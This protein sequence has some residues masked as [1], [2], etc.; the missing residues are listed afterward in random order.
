MVDEGID[1]D[2]VLENSKK[3]LSS[4]QNRTGLKAST[5]PEQVEMVLK[6]NPARFVTLPIPKLEE[7]MAILS[8]YAIYIQTEYNMALTKETSAKDAYQMDL[9]R[10][11][12]Q[13]EFP[14]SISTKKERDNLILTSNERVEKLHKIT[15]LRSRAVM[16]LE[17]QADRLE[18]LV[19]VLKKIHTRR[20]GP[21]VSSD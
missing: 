3:E 21:K 9:T 14:K 18:N 15:I 20:T 11:V 5:K 7:A 8:S 13:T 10:A 1:L 4:L 2:Q 17:S 19:N 6:T 16:F 12:S